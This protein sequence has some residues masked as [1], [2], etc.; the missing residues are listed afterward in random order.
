MT[1][2]TWNRTIRREGL[3]IIKW[4]PRRNRSHV[5][6]ISLDN[7]D[8]RVAVKWCSNKVTEGYSCFLFVLLSASLSLAKSMASGKRPDVDVR[9][10]LI[11]KETGFE[12]VLVE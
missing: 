11:G 8:K 7:V 2:T 1:P 4:L 9:V 6:F 5:L 3:K 10:L 12:D